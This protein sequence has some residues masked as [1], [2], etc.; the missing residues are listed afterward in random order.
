ML[1]LLMVLLS[2]WDTNI[3]EKD[4]WKKENIIWKKMVTYCGIG[5]ELFNSLLHGKYDSKFRCVVLK[6]IFWNIFRE[7][8]HRL[9]P[10]NFYICQQCFW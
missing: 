10:Q 7:I 8:A 9:M 1:W 6:H 2:V 4:R 3:Y 5:Y